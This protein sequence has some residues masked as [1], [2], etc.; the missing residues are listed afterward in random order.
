MEELLFLEKKN[1]NKIENN[2]NLNL[3]FDQYCEIGK[4]VRDAR[5]KSNLS[6]EELSNL[7]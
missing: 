7:S 3:E 1:D 2:E 5:I 4:L 6:I